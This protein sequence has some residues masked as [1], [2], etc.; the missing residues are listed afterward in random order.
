MI[1][2]AR[3]NE[4]VQ[5]VHEFWHAMDRDDYGAVLGALTPDARW[6]RG[7]KWREGREDI[8]AALNE[9]PKGLFIRH[10]VSQLVASE[11]AKGVSAQFLLVAHSR[12]AAEGEKPPFPVTAPTMIIDYSV[13]CVDTPNGPKLSYLAGQQA[14]NSTAKT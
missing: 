5:L 9:R 1:E 3:Y 4:V 14:F 13:E 10:M 8:G 2:T 7:E 6:K 11:T 12:R